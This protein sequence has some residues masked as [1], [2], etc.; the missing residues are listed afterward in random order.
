MR[1]AT[2]P[3]GVTAE[4]PLQQS[5]SGGSGSFLVRADDGRRYWCKTVNNLQHERVP[6]NEQVV[7]LLGVLIGAPVCEPQ[8][9]RM[10]TA[11]AG[12][13]FRPGRAIEQ[14]WAHGSLAVQPVVETHD[15]GSRASDDNA[16]RHVGIYALFDWTGGSDPQWLMAGADAEFYS[17]DHGH[18]FPGGPGWTIAGLQAA[19]TSAYQLGFPATDLDHVEVAR[20]ADRLEAVDEQDIAGCMSNLP[21]EWPVGDDELEALVDFVYGRREAVA[22]RLR[23]LVGR[24]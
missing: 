16:R 21:A 22:Q 7:S 4:A 13:E 14:G 17:H 23:G 3:I 2:S 8:L 6:V 19:G 1:R 20:V 18:Y 12:W 11:L 10:P 9:V 24:V 5:G 15:L